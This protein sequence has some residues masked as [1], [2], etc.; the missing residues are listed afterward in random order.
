MTEIE[1]HECDLFLMSSHTDYFAER[2]LPDFARFGSRNMDGWGIG[3]YNSGKGK[4]IRSEL[5]ASS[6]SVP[7]NVSREFAAAAR[8][9]SSPIIL[10]HLRR[11]TG[12]EVCLENSHPFKMSFLGYDWLM[13]HNGFSSNTSLVP[14]DRRLIRESTN[15]SPRVFEFLREHIISYYS[16]DARKSLITACKKAYASLLTADPN[17]KLNIIL[18]NGYLSFAFIHWRPFYLL[19]REKE[20]S[21]VALLSTLKLSEE[22]WIEFNCPDTPAA[23]MLVLSGPTL[24]WNSIVDAE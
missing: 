20:Q 12:S 1:Q 4:A 3:F 10:G 8:A 22:D 18:S 14:P 19:H 16:Q 23:K 11:S 17:G 13:I 15:D 7:G 21:D 6:A 24:I 2:S 5:P 9:L